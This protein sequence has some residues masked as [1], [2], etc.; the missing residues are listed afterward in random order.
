[1]GIYPPNLRRAGLGT[2]LT[3]LSAPLTEL[4]ITAEMDVPPDLDL[5]ADVE[6]LLFRA[7]RET[8]RNVER[9]SRAGGSVSAC[10]LRTAWPSS[11]WR[12][13]GSASRTRR[14]RCRADGHIGLPLLRDLAGDTGG[15]LVVDSVEGR[16]TKMRME[17]PFG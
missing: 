6:A 15:T 2:A 3:D 16:G 9:H 7:S 12:T 10:D 14:R 1:M 8:L 4:G 11:R 13:T 5:P 17:V